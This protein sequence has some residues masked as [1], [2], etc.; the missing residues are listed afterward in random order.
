MVEDNTASTSN[1]I[2][3]GW[4]ATSITWDRDAELEPATDDPPAGRANPHGH[5][6][7]RRTKQVVPRAKRVAKRRRKAA[8]AKNHRKIMRQIEAAKARDQK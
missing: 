6:P 7:G 5:P 2:E 4:R 1:V 3:V 8:L